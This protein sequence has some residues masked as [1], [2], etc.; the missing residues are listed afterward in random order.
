MG[1]RLGIPGA[2][3]FCFRRTLINFVIVFWFLV[4]AYIYS[5]LDELCYFSFR[6]NSFQELDTFF[7]CSLLGIAVLYAISCGDCDTTAPSPRIELSFLIH[8]LTRA[9][10]DLL[11]TVDS[12]ECV[13]SLSTTKVRR[14][15]YNMCC[16]LIKTV[17]LPISISN[18]ECYL[19]T[20]IPR[21]IHRFSSD[22]RS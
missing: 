12:L 11:S 21:W 7:S 16:Q 3:D 8:R 10:N 19:S 15:W 5:L 14:N 20:A 1:D 18:F 2:V 6:T 4:R 13:I 22:H 17:K 9:W